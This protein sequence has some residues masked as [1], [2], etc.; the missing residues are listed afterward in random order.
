MID[1]KRT[2]TDTSTELARERTVCQCDFS[3][4][5]HVSADREDNENQLF[6]TP[7]HMMVDVS[8]Q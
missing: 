4:K 1:E 6:R 3:E 8:G 5:R 7:R 2:D